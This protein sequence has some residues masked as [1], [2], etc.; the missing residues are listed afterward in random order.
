MSTEC[1]NAPSVVVSRWLSAHYA[2]CATHPNRPLLGP[3]TIQAS[4]SRITN[5]RTEAIIV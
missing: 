4:Q 1:E 2:Q 3:K 5:G